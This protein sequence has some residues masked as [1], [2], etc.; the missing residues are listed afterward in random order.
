VVPGGDIDD[1][2]G[3]TQWFILAELGRSTLKGADGIHAFVRRLSDASAK[4]GIEVSLLSRS[5][6][7]LGKTVTDANGYARFSAGL[8]RGTGGAAPALVLAKQGE[9][10]LAFMSLTEPAF[11]LSD[12]GVEGRAPAGPIDLFLTTDRGAYRA[13]E[14]IYATALARD[15]TATALDDVPITAILTRPDGVEYTRK[16]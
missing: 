12:R 10:D 3:A 14:T 15:G 4:E 7:V 13:G 11:D 5:N 6:R 2:A 9:D 8:A 1:D 16:L